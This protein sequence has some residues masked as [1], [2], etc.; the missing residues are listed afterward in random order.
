MTNELLELERRKE[1]EELELLELEELEL[2]E[3][4][5]LELE[6]NFKSNSPVLRRA[7][8]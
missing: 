2:L 5:E 1:E 6:I 3:L 8:T 7:Y 4:E